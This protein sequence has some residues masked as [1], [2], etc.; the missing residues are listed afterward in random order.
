[1]VREPEDVT[2]DHGTV[3]IAAIA[4]YGDTIHTLVDRSRY[5]GPYL[6]G[7]VAAESTFEPKPGQPKRLFQALDHIVGC[8][9]NERY[10]FE[11]KTW[12]MPPRIVLPK[13]VQEPHPPLWVATT[14]PDG[15]YWAGKMGVGVLSFSVGV[16]PE[17]VTMK[18]ARSPSRG[19]TGFTVSP[20]HTISPPGEVAVTAAVPVQPMPSGSVTPTRA[21]KP[22]GWA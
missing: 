19:V 6:P 2:D 18:V 21:V 4:T 3:R 16:P 11:G 8:W 9:T 1:M 5:D 17:V 20:L 7:Y 14:T 10:A 22:P 13:P 12:S 15:H